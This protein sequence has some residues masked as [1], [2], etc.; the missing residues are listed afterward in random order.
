[1]NDQFSAGPRLTDGPAG[2]PKR[3]AIASL[4]GYAYQLYVSA[5]AWIGLRQGQQLYLEVAED[6]AV[7]AAQAIEGV[8]VKDTAQSGTVTINSKDV[9]DAI[10]AF[11]D[12]VERN[13]E[14]QVTFRFLS[15]SDIGRERSV[16]DRADGEG[17]LTYWR[18]AA[19]GADVAPLRAALAKAELSEGVRQYIDTRTDDA[20]RADL[21]KR[22]HWDCGRPDLGAVRIELETSLVDYGSERLQLAPSESET[23]PAVLLEKILSTVVGV[24]P[25]RLVSAD[26]LRLCERHTRMSMSKAAIN[27]LMQALAGA[28]SNALVSTTTQGRLEAELELSLPDELASRSRLVTEARRR[29]ESARVL[30]L[31]GGTGVGKTVVARLAARSTCNPWY[32]LDLR[33]VP[34][35]ECARRLRAA[36]GQIS[37]IL[38][39]GLIL[40]DLNEAEDHAVA[41]ELDRLLHGL[42]RRDSLCLITSYRDP[43]TG[44]LDRLGANTGAVLRVPSFDEDE[45]GELIASAGGD[46]CVWAK[47]VHQWSGLGHPQLVRALIAGLR[48]RRW[49]VDELA[50]SPAE[51]G[52]NSDLEVE[53][54]VVRQRLFA[55]LQDESRRLLYRTSL[56]IGRFD[57]SLVLHL[58]GIAPQVD[59]PGERLDTLVGPWIDALGKGQ[60]R[61]SPL[62]ANTGR[63]TLVPQEQSSVHRVA[64]EQLTLGNSLD[65]RQANAAFVYAIEGKS[66][67]ALLKISSAVI[68]AKEDDCKRLASWLSGLREMPAELLIY[69]ENPTLSA[70][71]R[72]AQMLVV[73]QTNDIDAIHETWRALLREMQLES[74]AGL[75]DRFEYI[76]LA[77]SLISFPLAGVLP[78]WFALLRRFDELT[79]SRQEWRTLISEFEATTPAVEGNSI[80]LVGMLFVSQMM[81]LRTVSEQARLFAELDRLSPEVRNRY[82]VE[83]AQMPSDYA[84]L[85]NAPWLAEARREALDPVEAATAYLNMA[86]QAFGW[87]NREL[88]L[89]CHVAR[90]IMFDDYGNDEVAALNALVEAECALGTDPVLSRARAKIHFRHRRHATVLASLGE[91][92]ADLALDDPVERA[93]LCREIGISAAETGDWGKAGTWLGRAFTAAAL[94]TSMAM[95]PMIIGLRADEALAGYRAGDTEQSV[96]ILA[97]A[98]Q[99]LPALDSDGSIKAAYCQR[100]VR[101]GLLWMYGEATGQK[102]QVDKEPPAMVAGM[103]SNP[104]P[105]EAIRELPRANIDVAWYL[106]AAIEARHLGVAVADANLAKRLRGKTVQSL[107]LS[108]RTAFVGNAL[109]QLD[110][111]AFMRQFG[112]WVDGLA[113]LTEHSEELRSGDMIQPTYG[114]IPKA[115]LAQLETPLVQRSTEDAILAFGMF[116]AMSGDRDSVSA[117]SSALEHQAGTEAGRGLLAI[118]LG[119]DDSTADART[120]VST[121]I[122]TA[123]ANRGLT[124]EQLFIV[125]LRFVQAI[126]QSAFSFQLVKRF[127]AWS[128]AEWI[129]IIENRF[130]FRSPRITI[131]SIQSALARNHEDLSSIAALL[132]A[133]E[134]SVSVR[135]DPSLRAMLHSLTGSEGG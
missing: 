130:A 112:L 80:S 8:Q 127:V 82:L 73:A 110:V 38:P 98:L 107:E 72:F 108:T 123:L 128:R 68:G 64:V 35:A 85:V 113:Y 132:L 43:S 45:V 90:A 29:V 46:P 106:M 104:E 4:R 69:P 111:A 92:A 2:D 101:H 3:Q 133:A 60:L 59:M 23:L 1:M 54:R 70:T 121:A 56:L 115:S 39:A 71:L 119:N 36:L 77:K 47:H 66:E 26:L 134:D 114:S 118:M 109:S 16:D 117:L 74:G 7:V 81:G 76:V 25:R 93:F 37:D 10:A 21:L 18:S 52:T 53:R 126:R 84:L 89:R 48:S 11:V 97:E 124:P 65:V 94:T 58:A 91:H 5:L 44:L 51:A 50:N 14:A 103:C 122:C 20:L 67:H 27:T 9:R 34:A 49:P 120:F 125:T 31:T 116:A 78:D 86:N 83:A 75:G 30:F 57:R 99:L 135:L 6:Y 129:K 100:V 42:R 95:K 33:D 28:S 87:G 22:M 41:Q 96:I 13:P 40:D 131:P 61:N 15:T 62:V 55:A 19:A 32:V 88:A 24:E 63:E 12:L 105:P 17:V 79:N 102:L